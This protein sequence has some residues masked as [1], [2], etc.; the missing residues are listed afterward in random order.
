[1]NVT[2]ADVGFVTKSV[3]NYKWVILSV[4]SYAVLSRKTY[5]AFHIYV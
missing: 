4:F 1:M 5:C 2:D 3:I